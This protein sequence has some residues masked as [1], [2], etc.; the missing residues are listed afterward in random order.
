METASRELSEQLYQLSGW[1]ADEWWHEHMIVGLD[2]IV[3]IKG[4][5][6]T[7]EPICPAYD[8]SFLLRKLPRMHYEGRTPYFLTLMNGD[9][10][11]TN[12]ICDYMGLMQ[13]WLH[14]YDKAKL[15]EA[16]TPENAACK[17]CISLFRRC[18]LTKDS[19]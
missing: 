15:V 17:L 4:D 12:W 3:T 16:D 2:P 14:Q 8:L 11:A 10:Q 9:Q 19:A 5:P 7:G 1:E 6:E 13:Q 18:L